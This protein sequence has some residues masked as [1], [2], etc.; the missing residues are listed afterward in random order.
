MKAVVAAFNQEKA[1]VGAFSVITNLRMEPFEALICSEEDVEL[2]YKWGI[3][4]L[5][6][7]TL[8][9]LV[10]NPVR[11]AVRQTINFYVKHSEVKN[12][13]LLLLW[14]RQKQQMQ[15]ILCEINKMENANT[16]STNCAIN[17]PL[18]F[19]GW[20]LIFDIDT[21]SL[22]KNLQKLFH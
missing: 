18:S 7:K 1:L 2:R 5:K 10:K 12:E 20:F 22:F 6:Q 17:C 8:P 9:E 3:Q 13:L 14:Q 21:N 19:Q 16:L 11:A 15:S 4:Y